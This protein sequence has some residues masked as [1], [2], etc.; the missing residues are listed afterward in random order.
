MTS[1]LA[2]LLAL[3]GA[4]ALYIAAQSARSESSPAAYIDASQNLPGWTYIFAGSGALLAS[5]GPYDYLRLLSVYGFQANQLVLSLT[6]VA[7][8]T[9]LW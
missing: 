4:F 2:I 8:V 9:A 3:F 1:L 7:L 5:V 6:L